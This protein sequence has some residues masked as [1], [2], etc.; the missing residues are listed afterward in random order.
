MNLYLDD[1]M[2]NPLLAQYLRQAGHDVQMPADAG[3]DSAEDPE[4]L[5]YTIK[6]D[7][8][9]LTGNHGDFEMLH[10]LI[11]QARGHHPGILVVRRD[12][13][14]SRDLTLKGIVRAL[15]KLVAAG[16]PVADQC[17]VLNHWR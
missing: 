11:G 14:P 3:L 1:D 12:N 4:H 16:I 17:V 10:N 7:R 8:V 6:V 13:D 9:L 2:K 5:T 15:T